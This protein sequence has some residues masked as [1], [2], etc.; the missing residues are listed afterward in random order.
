MKPPDFAAGHFRCQT[1]GQTGGWIETKNP[2]GTVM[3]S[4]LHGFHPEG[5]TIACNQ[6][7]EHW[8]APSSDAASAA[9]SLT[10]EGSKPQPE[11]L[12]RALSKYNN[13]LALSHRLLR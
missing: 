9:S 10:L 3:V 6:C 13:R 1:C 7:G 2:D 5:S 12:N 4:V 8:R 11:R